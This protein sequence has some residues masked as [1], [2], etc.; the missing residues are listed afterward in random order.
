MHVLKGTFYC[1]FL[2]HN[3]PSIMVYH[4]FTQTD[5]MTMSM[6]IIA[7]GTQRENISTRA[8]KPTICTHAR[9]PTYAHTCACENECEEQIEK[10][11]ESEASHQCRLVPPHVPQLPCNQRPQLTKESCRGD[12]Q[13]FDISKFQASRSRSCHQ[14]LKSTWSQ[15]GLEQNAKL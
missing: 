2:V 4:P 7:S 13:A 14:C 6:Y 3:A 9:R 15:R 10:R 12:I 1:C 11:R 5:Q 8:G